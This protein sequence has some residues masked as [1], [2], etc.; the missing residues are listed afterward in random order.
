M[1]DQNRKIDSRPMS[2]EE[3]G[4]KGG[5]TTAREHPEQYSK[6]GKKA[7]QNRSD[8][9]SSSEAVGQTSQSN[10]SDSDWSEGFDT[11]R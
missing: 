3:R 10:N 7:R 11:D 5:E 1:T 2:A 4:R 8:G 9:N 6:M